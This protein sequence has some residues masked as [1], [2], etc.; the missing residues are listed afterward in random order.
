MC[1]VVEKLDKMNN[2]TKAILHRAVFDYFEIDADANYRKGERFIKK[3]LPISF[4]ENETAP[5]VCV[6]GDTASGESY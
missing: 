5:S 2:A 6:T 3:I 1:E 4:W